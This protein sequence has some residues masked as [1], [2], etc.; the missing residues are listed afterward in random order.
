MQISSRKN[1]TNDDTLKVIAA[2]LTTPS[3]DQIVEQLKELLNYETSSM[4]KETAS[5]CSAPE[6]QPGK[7]NMGKTQAQNHPK[8]HSVIKTF[9]IKNHKDIDAI[10]II[11]CPKV[12][13]Y[14]LFVVGIN[15][16]LRASDL[17]RIKLGD[18]RYLEIS[19]HHVLREKKTKKLRGLT[20][21]KP[22][23]EAIHALLA[24]MPNATDDD[25]LFQSQR[26][27]KPLTTSYLNHLVKKWCRAIKLKGNYGSHTLRKTWGYHARV[28]FGVDLPTLVDCF[29]HAT[30]RQTLEYLCIQEEEVKRAFMNEL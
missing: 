23:Y 24:K 13:D 20:V 14:C 21:N 15:S 28:T 29:G 25:Y 30:Q 8:K 12:R 6:P 11:L 17:T 5:S 3:K 9:P 27:K 1:Q 10:K 26:G 7:S 2:L 22:M 18:V 16:A 4:P 19:D